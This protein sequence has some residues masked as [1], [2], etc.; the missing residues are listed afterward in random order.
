MTQH[1]V[2]IQQ[3]QHILQGVLRQGRDTA[4]LLQR[5]GIPPA[6]LQAPLARV[7]L[8]QYARLI[9]V[10]R[11]AT[12]D[13]LWGLCRTP[14]RPGSFG[15]CAL[16]LLT[17]H[18][19]EAA[20]RRGFCM[21]HGQTGD[22]V[23]R[24]TV[25]GGLARVQLVR[26]R[27]TS[28]DG[29]DDPACPT[30]KPHN[31]AALDYAQK[32]V[33][34]FCFGLVCWLVARRVPLLAV[35]YTEP[36]P[37]SDSSRVYQAPIRYDAPHIGLCFEARWLALPVVQNRQSLQEFLAGAPANL[38]IRYR[39][40]SSVS[41]RI[42]RL[43]QR[44]L[45]SV[46]PSLQA[47]GELMAMTPQ[48]LR[49]RLREEGHGFQA[50]KDALRRDTAIAC[51]ALPDLTLIDIANRVGFSEASTFCRAFK[52]WTGVAPGEYRLTRIAKP[53]LSGSARPGS[54]PP[55]SAP[56][57]SAPPG[58]APQKPAAAARHNAGLPTPLSE[59]S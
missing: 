38:L 55:G 19:L 8:A 18:D 14:L 27:L 57:G 49:R 20:L 13:E 30:G 32:A 34:L 37:R 42:R 41:E 15:Q 21:L 28:P 3:V 40:A 26:R 31:P 56:P 25:H 10:L 1:T 4:A 50:L 53:L 35:D 5:A 54:A 45:D 12:R 16:Q 17:C 46:L 43:L 23:G 11:R 36:I 24:L 47:V 51:L 44:R 52:K 2:A 6:L 33:L 39:D 29:P 58:S 9:R 22:F 7:S 48:T 59:G